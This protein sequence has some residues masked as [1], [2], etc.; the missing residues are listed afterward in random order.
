[1]T[2]AHDDTHAHVC[3][4]LDHDCRSG[5]DHPREQELFEFLASLRARTAS[6]S[7]AHRVLRDYLALRSTSGYPLRYPLHSPTS[8]PSAWQRTFRAIIDDHLSQKAGA[9][10]T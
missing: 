2:P 3:D 10:T 5:P 6:N 9:T 7:A 8:C 1:M 4:P